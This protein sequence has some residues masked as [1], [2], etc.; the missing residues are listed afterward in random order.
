L[1]K[2]I[3]WDNTQKRSPTP[4]LDNVGASTS[5]NPMGFQ[6]LLL[7]QLY[8]T[9]IDASKVRGHKTDAVEIWSDRHT[10]RQGLRTQDWRTN[11]RR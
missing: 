9:I 11:D 6:G 5:H 10:S 3:F 4:G 7:G 8:L 1:Y 2:N